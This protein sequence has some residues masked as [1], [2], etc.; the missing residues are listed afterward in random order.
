[1]QGRGGEREP[2]IG[3]Q[4]VVAEE[5][6]Q[7]AVKIVAAGAGD[8][9]DDAAGEASVFGAVAV[10][11][12]AELFYR[13]GVRRD[14]AGVT[15]AGHVGAAIQVI[16]DRTGAAVHAAVD[17]G[18]LLR[19]PQHDAVRG[20]GDARN[21]VEQGIHV[22]ADN[23]QGG[24][25]R[26]LDGAPDLRVVGVHQRSAARDVD[27]FGHRADVE[28]RVHARIHVDV[29]CDAL[30]Y[31]LLEA[32]G[33]HFQG[34][35]ANRHELEAVRAFRGC[36]RTTYEVGADVG[37]RDLRARHDGPGSVAHCAIE[38]GCGLCADAGHVTQGDQRAHQ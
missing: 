12:H 3:V 15:Q 17:H 16:V 35:G 2:R 38:S 30:L 27:F 28:P 11:D 10:G 7:G 37:C 31:K 14:V 5:L 20:G 32:G 19:K 26:V 23:G 6:E 9:V 18:A 21:Q 8:D 29:E 13:I 1:M 22:A 36:L 25:F 33:G 4:V 24:D 34:V